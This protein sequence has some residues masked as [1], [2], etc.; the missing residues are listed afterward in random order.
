MKAKSPVII[1]ILQIL[2]FLLVPLFVYLF[3]VNSSLSAVGPYVGTYSPS[4]EETNYLTALSVYRGE[5]LY[6]NFSISY[7][8]GRFLAQALY[9]HLTQPTIISARIYMNLFAPLLFPTLLFFL[10]YRVLRVLKLSFFPAYLLGWL[11]LL[12]DLTIVHSAQ[13]V[14]ALIAGFCLVLLSRLKFHQFFLGL[15]LGLIFLFRFEAGIIVALSL[16]LAYRSPPSKQNILGFGVVW[17]PVLAN[18][19]FHGTLANFFYDTIVLGLI[20]QPRVMGQPIPPNAL[21]YVFLSSLLALFGFT[22]SLAAHSNKS[23]RTVAGIALFSYVSALGRSDEGH[24]WYALLWLPLLISYSLTQLDRIR[25][26]PTIFIG[27]GLFAA[28]YLIIVVKSP[29]LF[30]SIAAIMLLLADRLKSFSR[31]ITLAG[32]ITALLIFHSFQYFT[33]RFQLPRYVGTLAHPWT[34]SASGGSIG[35]LDFPFSTLTSLLEIKLHITGNS[36]SLFIFPENTIY[37]EY[38]KL[39]RPTRYLYL[40]GERTAGTETEII[41]DLESTPNLYILVF[42]V[43]AAHRGGEVW[44]WIESHTEVIYSAPYQSTTVELRHSSL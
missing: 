37:Y 23:L 15:L 6:K 4:D 11:A 39:P 42:P 24:L 40:T 26:L 32:I 14:H 33:L 22:L 19:L 36:P 20:M 8:P 25:L 34:Q 12:L 17:L 2:S 16:I 21:W 10:T 9:F 7:P 28:C 18:L 13:E 27:L 41:L 5:G 1:H 30:L 38:F 43:K 35:G 31:E 3:I 44:S 29:A